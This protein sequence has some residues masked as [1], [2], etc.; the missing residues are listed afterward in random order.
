[1]EKGKW[2]IIWACRS[3]R[4]TKSITSILLNLSQKW[5]CSVIEEDMDVVSCPKHKNIDTYKCSGFC[6]YLCMYTCVHV[7]L[8]VCVDST[9]LGCKCK[10]FLIT[11]KPESP[12]LL[13]EVVSLAEPVAQL[14]LT[15]SQSLRN[16]QVSGIM[17]A[18]PVGF[19]YL[20]SSHHAWLLST[21]P[22]EPPPPTLT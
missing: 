6:S 22:N 3:I 8:F 13:M 14:I 5:E 21:L 4:V 20:N 17:G 1:M 7:Y 12:T 15:T 18:D 10:Y 9:V 19:E 2:R 11:Q 16:I